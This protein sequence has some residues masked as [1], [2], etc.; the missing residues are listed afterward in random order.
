MQTLNIMFNPGRLKKLR[1]DNGLSQP[2]MSERLCIPQSSYSKFETN[3]AQL[4][5]QLLQKIHEEFGI[6]PN[7]F[8]LPDCKTINFKNGST[9]QGNGVVQTENYYSFP[10]EIID[11]ILNSQQNIIQLISMVIKKEG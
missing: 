10:K 2:E 9:V 3:K 11:S 6:D 1:K 5:L 8:I 7:E 4:N